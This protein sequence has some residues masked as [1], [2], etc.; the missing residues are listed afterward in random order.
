MKRDDNL[1]SMKIPLLCF[2][3]R[4]IILAMLGF[5][6]A[7]TLLAAETNATDQVKS[8]A[9]LTYQW[10]KDGQAGTNATEQVKS[11]AARLK[12]QP[13]YSWKVEL[14][15]PGMPITPGLLHGQTEKGGLSMVSQ[16]FNDNTL[17]A[18]F[19]ADKA[20][21]KIEDEWQLVGAP[22]AAGA[23]GRA[24]M[25]GQWLIRNRTPAEEVEA[26]LK[27][28]KPLQ[29]GEEG[30][31][32]AELT[33]EGA[34]SLL[35]FG[36]RGGTPPPAPKNA[37]ASV[38]FWLK[39]GALAKFESH[40][41]GTTTFGPDQEERELDMTRTVEIQDVGSTKLAVPAEARKKLEA[42]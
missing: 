28:S 20:V 35:S 30:V 40:V 23:D 38:K 17:Q 18:A 37:K 34:K 32:G 3:M 19:N 22:D 4:S 21:V 15:L 7:G 10:Y 2:T 1:H 42:K 8:A 36:S 29:A 13:N 24:A 5:L 26:L 12:D 27:N 9:P 11:A 16:E 41:S 31:L 6:S 14:K 33:E 25:I 39:D